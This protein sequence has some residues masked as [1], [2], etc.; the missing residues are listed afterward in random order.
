MGHTIIQDEID[1]V[2]R[3]VDALFADHQPD[4]L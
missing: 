2:G 3:I 4:M 1:H